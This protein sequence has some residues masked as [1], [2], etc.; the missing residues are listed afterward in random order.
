MLWPRA[1]EKSGN[2]HR[3]VVDAADR[4]TTKWHKGEA[5]KKAGYASQQ[6]TQRAPTK[7][8]WGGAAMIQL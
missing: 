6:R 4:I 5:E 3:G 8:I 7:E 1:A 2:W